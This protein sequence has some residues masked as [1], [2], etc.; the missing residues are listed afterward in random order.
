MRSTPSRMRFG[1]ATSLLICTGC[2]TEVSPAGKRH[3]ES[4]FS[5]DLRLILLQSENSADSRACT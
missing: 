5:R 4:L 2:G 3:T 1:I